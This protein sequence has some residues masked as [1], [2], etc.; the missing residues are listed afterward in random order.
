MDLLVV[1]TYN[2]TVACLRKFDLWFS[3]GLG[4]DLEIVEILCSW[5]FAQFSALVIQ[6]KK[7]IVLKDLRS[8]GHVWGLADWVEADEIVQFSLRNALF[9]G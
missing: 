2:K 5:F 9:S 4:F 7:E 6:H 1:A 8:Q 3:I